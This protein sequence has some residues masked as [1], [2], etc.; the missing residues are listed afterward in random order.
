MDFHGVLLLRQDLEVCVSVS[1]DDPLRRAPGVHMN[2]SGLPSEGPVFVGG[3]PRWAVTQ[4]VSGG[5][6]SDDWP[7]DR[8]FI[9]P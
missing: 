9:P 7:S 1:L 5:Y 8:D 6:Q 2:G 3:R 4:K